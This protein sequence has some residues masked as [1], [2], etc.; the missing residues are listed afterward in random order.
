MKPHWIPCGEKLPEK[1]GRYLVWAV[2]SFVPE[3][4]ESFTYQITTIADFYIWK[5]EPS[6]YGDHVKEVLAWRE[7]PEPWR[8]EKR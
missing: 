7:L 3:H 5:G 2:V 6:W 4:G 1:E 8:E